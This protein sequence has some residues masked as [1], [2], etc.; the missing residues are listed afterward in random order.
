MDWSPILTAQPYLP[1][2]GK[3]NKD[4]GGTTVPDVSLETAIF[5]IN[6]FLLSFP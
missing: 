6:S 4:M 1:H 3:L 2:L 5:S